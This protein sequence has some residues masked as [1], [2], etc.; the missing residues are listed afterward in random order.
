VNGFEIKREGNRIGVV[1]EGDLT[2]SVV[3]ELKPFLQKAITDEIGQVE[4]DLGK[5]VFLDSTGI[6]L[7]VATYNSMLKKKGTV[8][9]ISVSED[10]FHLLQSMRIEKRLCVQKS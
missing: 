7:L 6:G 4:F 3:T 1:F 10:I 5:T 9:V 2:V 8:S